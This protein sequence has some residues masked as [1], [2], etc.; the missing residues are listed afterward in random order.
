MTEQPKETKTESAPETV[1]PEKLRTIIA[2]LEAKNVS[3]QCP[4]CT[5]NKWNA[6]VLGIVVHPLRHKG[7][8]VP[9]PLIPILLLTCNNC[10]WTAMHNLNVL[11]IEP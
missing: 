1:T 7:F 6:E 4:R 10:G 8:S 5:N 9:P 11:G 3:K 2:A